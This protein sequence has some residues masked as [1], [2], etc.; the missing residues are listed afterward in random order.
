[1]MATTIMSSIRVK[2]ACSCFFME[3]F[4]GFGMN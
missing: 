2:P 1:M 4:S 3:W